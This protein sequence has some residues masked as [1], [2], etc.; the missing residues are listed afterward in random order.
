MFQGRGCHEDEPWWQ[1]AGP[2][3]FEPFAAD[4]GYFERPEQMWMLDPRVRNLDAKVAQLRAAGI[5][6]TVDPEN[7]PFGRFARTPDPEGNP[8]ECWQP[9][10]TTRPMRLQ[11]SAASVWRLLF[12]LPHHRVCVTAQMNAPTV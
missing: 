3:A 4:T 10:G 9:H 11:R 2:T 6:V 7:H 1:E 5:K 8:I 12:L